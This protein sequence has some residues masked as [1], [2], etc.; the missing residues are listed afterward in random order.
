MTDS[1]LAAVRYSNDNQG[2]YVYREDRLIFSGGWPHRLFAQDSHLNLLRVELNFGHDLDDYF[3][4]DIRKS[5]INIPAKQRDELKTVLAPW[6]NEAQK[7]YRGE[8]S[9]RA[10]LRAP[11]TP[12][13]NQVPKRL[14]VRT[15]IRARF[16]SRRLIAQAIVSSSS[17]FGETTINRAQVVEGTEVLSSLSLP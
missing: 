6:R 3:E 8:R 11:V 14:N 13:T 16:L 10:E 5:K 7:R 9:R 15:L 12:F 4:I 2:F 1:E 17:R